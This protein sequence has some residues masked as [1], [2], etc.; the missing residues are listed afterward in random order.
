MVRAMFVLLLACAAR[1]PSPPPGAAAP[2]AERVRAALAADVPEALTPYRA[3]VAAV[4][5]FE[6]EPGRRIFSPEN[7]YPFDTV[8]VADEGAVVRVLHESAGIRV[9]V[10]VRRED[11]AERPDDGAPVAPGP[12]GRVPDDTFVR[13][14]GGTP[15]TLGARTPAAA[16]VTWEAGGVTLD[17]WA[18]ADTLVRVWRASS[19][20]SERWS[21]LRIVDPTNG[22]GRVTLALRDAPDGRVLAT[23]WP[24]VELTLR[25]LDAPAGGWR[26]V[27]ALTDAVHAVGWVA[28]DAVADQEPL[29]FG[30]GTGGGTPPLRN[31]RVAE[32]AAGTWIRPEGAAAPF[33]RA[34]RDAHVELVENDG[35]RLRVRLRSA[36]GWL[37]GEVD[38]PRR[39][40]KTGVVELRCEP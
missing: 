29:G 3:T 21:D 16:R 36:W 27:E 20:S 17:G 11:L 35:A 8:V 9:V 10:G 33:A 15:V 18:R 24:D 23:L 14:A 26:R 22:D 7:V 32:L 30:Y 40:P 5:P 34:V 1:V 13:L 2:L 19:D 28:A 38:C 31:M 39:T 6:L 37:P 4:G 25:A 12:D